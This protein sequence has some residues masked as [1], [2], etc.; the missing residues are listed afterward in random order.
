MLRE[1]GK[2]ARL[3]MEKLLGSRV[4]SG[5]VGPYSEKV[6]KKNPRAFKGVLVINKK[7]PAVVS[8]CSMLHA[9]C[10]LK[11]ER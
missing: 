10:W 5:V 11:A 4:F 2:Q 9:L 3:D 6:A 7:T 8:L 1:I